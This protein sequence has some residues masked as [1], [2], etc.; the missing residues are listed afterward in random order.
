[1]PSSGV[2]F[3]YKIRDATEE[4][5]RNVTSLGP[6]FNFETGSAVA[7]GQNAGVCADLPRRFFM[8]RK[9][10]PYIDSKPWVLER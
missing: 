9:V 7:D 1:M 8:V 6:Q 10:Q 2:K 5:M 4:A 3:H